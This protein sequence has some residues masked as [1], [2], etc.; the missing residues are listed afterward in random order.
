MNSLMAFRLSNQS[1]QASR[2]TDKS[3]SYDKKTD[4]LHAHAKNL[5]NHR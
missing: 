5:I 1:L 2:S 4:I 3:G